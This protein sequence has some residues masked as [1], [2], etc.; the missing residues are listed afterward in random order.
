MGAWFKEKGQA[1]IV[2]QLAFIFY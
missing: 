2:V 1:A